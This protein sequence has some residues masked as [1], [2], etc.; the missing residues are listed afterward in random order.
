[1]RYVS[2]LLKLTASRRRT[3]FYSA[4]RRS[5]ILGGREKSHRPWLTGWQGYL[6][7]RRS[8]IP[9]RPNKYGETFM[10]DRD[11]E[12]VRRAI[13]QHD[14]FAFPLDAVSLDAGDGPMSMADRAAFGMEN[15]TQDL[16]VATRVAS[17]AGVYRDRRGSLWVAHDN[18][19][20]QQDEYLMEYVGNLDDLNVPLKD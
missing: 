15:V 6:T 16:E 5:P 11:L 20:A 17:G 10:A 9:S 13:E 7:M 18:S 3:G 2:A 1:M 8:M 12:A 14:N 4:P 19:H